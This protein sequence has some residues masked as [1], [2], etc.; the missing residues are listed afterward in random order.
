M[1]DRRE[2]ID[3]WTEGSNGQ[4]NFKVKPIAGEETGRKVTNK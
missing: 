2:K 4:K 3:K 1:D